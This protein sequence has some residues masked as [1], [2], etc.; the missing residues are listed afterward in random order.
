MALLCTPEASSLLPECTQTTPKSFR[1]WGPTAIG[2]IT[3][4]SNFAES[5]IAPRSGG[6]GT[7]LLRRRRGTSHVVLGGS[8]GASGHGCVFAQESVFLSCEDTR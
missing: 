6:G 8:C 2:R 1:A 7:C 3:A 4:G 5:R